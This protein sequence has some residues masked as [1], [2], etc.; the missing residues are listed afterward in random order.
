MCHAVMFLLESLRESA[1]RDSRFSP[2]LNLT[3]PTA[4]PFHRNSSDIPTRAILGPKQLPIIRRISL[5][6][7]I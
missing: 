4:Q 6:L 1:I 5:A 2:S 3:L 7:F